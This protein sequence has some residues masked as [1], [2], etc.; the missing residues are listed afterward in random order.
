M[1][2]TTED[3]VGRGARDGGELFRNWYDGLTT[4]AAKN[5][6]A[7]YVFVM[8]SLAEIVRTFD[9]HCVFPEINSLQTAVRHCSDEYL[10]LAEDH[11]FSPDVCGYVKADYALQLRG[12][13]HPMGRIPPPS[14]A[15]QTNAC[16]TYL[17]WSEIW[18]RMYDIPV[19]TVDVPG[20]RSAPGTA[21]LSGESVER[22]RQYVLY[23]IKELI[24]H[25]ETLT[26]KKFDVDRLREVLRLTNRMGRAWRRVLELNR[27]R[28]A[29]FDAMMEGTIYLGVANALRGTEE[30]AVYFENLVEEME[31]KAEHS[32]S[33]LVDH[34]KEHRLVFVG[35]PCYPIFRRFYQLFSEWGGVFVSSTYTWFASGG[36]NLDFEYD[37]EN[38]VE[39]LAEGVMLSVQRAGDSMLFHDK[40]LLD[41]IDEFGAD[42]V[43]YHPIK[44]CRTVSTSLADSRRVVLAERDVLCLYIESDMMDKRVVSEAQLKNRIDAFFEGLESRRIRKATA[45]TAAAPGA[46]QSATTP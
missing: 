6:K 28:P 25:L 37:L 20:S 34:D 30:G 7:A 10:S 1:T 22:D 35:V 42:G 3:I 46:E 12:G 18:E 2:A 27:A 5:E 39:S 17:K 26:G 21:V 4:A 32:I 44:S 23:Q 40:Y 16:N 45:G 31:Y 9:L 41:G 33:P 13:E 19:V 11:G 14:I 38:P 24:S 8:G 15:V 43:V 36:L 29:V